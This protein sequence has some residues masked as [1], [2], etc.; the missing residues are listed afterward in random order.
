MSIWMLAG[1]PLAFLRIS[2]IFWTARIVKGRMRMRKRVG[3][4]LS[5]DLLDIE[6]VYQ[7]FDILTGFDKGG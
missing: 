1:T 7:V 6:L 5:L 2:I 4:S 3:I